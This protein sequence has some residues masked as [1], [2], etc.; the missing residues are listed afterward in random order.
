MKFCAY[1]VFLKG[2]GET[3]DVFLSF[4]FVIIC[5]LFHF[6]SALSEIVLMQNNGKAVVL[7][8]LRSDYDQ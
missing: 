2:K 1:A 6:N 5:M 8:C 7:K 3:Q 4:N